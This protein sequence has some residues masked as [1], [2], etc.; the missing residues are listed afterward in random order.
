MPKRK[1]KQGAFYALLGLRHE[2]TENTYLAI[3]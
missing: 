2:T 3:T 1:Y